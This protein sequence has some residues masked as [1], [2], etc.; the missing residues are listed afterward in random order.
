M[1]MFD[2]AMQEGIR[3]GYESACLE[4]CEGADDPEDRCPIDPR[5]C[6]CQGIYYSRLPWWKKFF[7]ENR[8]PSEKRVR[9]RVLLLKFKEVIAKREQ[10]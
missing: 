2:K 3:R 8:R 7:V 1:G 6:V 10:I 5:E 9:Q 4:M